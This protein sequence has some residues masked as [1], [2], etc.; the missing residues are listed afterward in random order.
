M[1]FFSR[2]ANNCNHRCFLQ[3]AKLFHL[4]LRQ[5]EANESAMHDFISKTVI[6]GELLSVKLFAI[7]DINFTCDEAVPPNQI[8]SFHQ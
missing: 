7:N 8:G 6:D 4:F 1:K 3:C 5:V 2:L